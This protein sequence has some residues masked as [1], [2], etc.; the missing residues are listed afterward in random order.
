MFVNELFLS[1]KENNLKLLNW[2]LF[3]EL[4][5]YGHVRLHIVVC[6]T[7]I[8]KLLVAFLCLRIDKCLSACSDAPTHLL[9][10][11]SYVYFDICIKYDKERFLCKLSDD[12][13]QT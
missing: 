2:P 12:M 10:S 4:T 9:Y 13:K 5:I 1:Q 7:A 3:A 8:A 6:S 11:C